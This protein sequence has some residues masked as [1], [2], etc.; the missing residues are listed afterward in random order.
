MYLSN[1]FEHPYYNSVFPPS[2][3]QP[4]YLQMMKFLPFPQNEETILAVI[5]PIA[6]Y[7]SNSSSSV[8][9]QTEYAIT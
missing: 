2:K 7:I 6:D 8:T 9:I 3:I 5:V 1:T 4:S